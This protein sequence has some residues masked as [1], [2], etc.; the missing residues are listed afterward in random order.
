M[1]LNYQIVHRVDSIK[2]AA[3]AAFNLLK[4]RAL[5]IYGMGEKAHLRL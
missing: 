5:I 4:V 3:E 2:K 1:G